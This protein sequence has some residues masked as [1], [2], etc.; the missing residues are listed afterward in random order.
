MY[1][2]SDGVR[3][4]TDAVVTRLNENI[5]PHSMVTLLKAKANGSIH[6]A[7]KFIFLVPIY[8]L[9][10]TFECAHVPANAT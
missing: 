3:T 10:A 5:R 6:T 7:A 4:V 8:H 2:V 1:V 9:A